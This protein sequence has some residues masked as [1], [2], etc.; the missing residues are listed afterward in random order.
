MSEVVVISPDKLRDLVTGAVAA[1]VRSAMEHLARSMPSE[2]TDAEASEYMGISAITLR[3]WRAQKRG[4]A[5]HKS[6]RSVRYAKK[7][8]DDWLRSNRV[9]TVDSLQTRH[10]K[11]CL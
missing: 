3:T 1:G 11:S 6:G 4:P 10:E 7:D 9:L 2:M 5:Y 8:I